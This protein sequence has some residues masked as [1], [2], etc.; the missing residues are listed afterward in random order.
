MALDSDINLLRKIPTFRVLGP[1]ALRI[2]AISAETVHIR[3]GE[4]LYESGDPGD[5]AYVIAAGAIKFRSS[6]SHKVEELPIARA[7]SLIG[8]TALIIETVRPATAAALEPSTL[9]KITRTIFLRMLEGDADAAFALRA[10]I[11]RRTRSIL[12]DLELVLPKF[13]QEN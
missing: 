13:E 11:A 4:T 12:D 8:E 6:G 10:L 2:L 7:G 9:M 5:C 3:S 1:D